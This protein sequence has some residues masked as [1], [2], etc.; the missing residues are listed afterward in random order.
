M[1]L[2]L[3]GLCV[4]SSAPIALD[5]AQ[6]NF[7]RTL[8][9]V[10]HGTYVPD[11]K[12]DPESGPGLTPLGIAQA[13]LAAARLAALPIRFQSITS[14]TLTRAQQTAA[15]IRTQ[16]PE[17]PGTASPLLSEC[18][19]PMAGPAGD[20]ASV[21]QTACKQRLDM[22]FA[23]FAIAA[24]DSDK[25]DV[26]VCHGNVIRY[27]VTRALGVDTRAWPALSV[28]NASLTMIR[29]R[30]DGSTQVIAVGDA[31]HIPPNLQSFG[32]D[33]DPQLV[34]PALGVFATK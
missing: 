23:K 21:E 1:Q 9:L 20:G 14:S 19:P 15:E 24:L 25:N 8:F 4:L 31:G 7:T 2:C 29:I 12:A 10:R 18:T 6:S 13:R 16:L 34:T 26:L 28:A 32:S 27:F 5:A 11:P 30:R 3:I 33:A 22:A 17:V